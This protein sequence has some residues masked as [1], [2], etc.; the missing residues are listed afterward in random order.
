MQNFSF[1]EVFN[2]CCCS[3]VNTHVRTYWSKCDL[4]HLN[5]DVIGKTETAAEDFRYI[6]TK[7]E[8]RD[9]LPADMHLHSSSG[10]STEKLAKQY[11]STLKK[12]EVEELYKYYQFDFEAFGYDYREYLAVAKVEA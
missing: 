5:F 6:T 9:S 1:F 3:S 10:G 11:F 4:C 2:R 7:A 8:L 12:G